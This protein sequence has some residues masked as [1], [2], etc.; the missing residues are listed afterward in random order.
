MDLPQ[1]CPGTALP[2]ELAFRAFIHVE[3]IL[4]SLHMPMDSANPS[5]FKPG[6]LFLPHLGT[7][8]TERAAYKKILGFLV[9]L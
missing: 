6:L 1:H 3:T 4:A 9:A 8:D 5:T 7:W 2:V